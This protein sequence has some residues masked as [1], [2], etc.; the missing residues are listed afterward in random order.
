MS[1]CENIWDSEHEKSLQIQNGTIENIMH[2][3]NVDYVKIVCKFP[4]RTESLSDFVL[5]VDDHTSIHC[6]NGKRITPRNL[7]EGMI[8]DAWVSMA[9]TRSIPPQ[10]RA[11]RIIVK[12]NPCGAAVTDGR[13]AEVDLHNHFLYTG[14]PGRPESQ[15]RFV[16]S[17]DT[18]ILDRYGNRMQLRDIKQGDRVRVEHAD[19]MT[20]SIPPQTSAFMIKKY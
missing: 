5:V 13:V 19:F 20:A 14:Q 10:T 8:I 3:G 15:I 11:Y 17:E 6:K 18:R 16:V 2:S 9:M 12:S 7:R 4:E 1:F